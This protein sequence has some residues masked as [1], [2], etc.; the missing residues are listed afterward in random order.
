MNGNTTAA[1]VRSA[2]TDTVT[3]ELRR[4]DL[5]ALLKNVG[6]KVTRSRPL[7]AHNALEALHA[8]YDSP[9]GEA[10]APS[11]STDAERDC[12]MPHLRLSCGHCPHQL[13][14]DCG[15]CCSCP[16]GKS[17]AQDETATCKALEALAELLRRGQT[18]RAGRLVASSCPSQYDI[19]AVLGWKP[20]GD[21][22]WAPD[23]SEQPVADEDMGGTRAH[24][25]RA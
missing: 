12:C 23:K 16:R 6:G 18:W 1:T 2:S 22:A 8:A 17:P 13:C 21:L 10:V 24:A 20:P 3:V 14:Q 7:G 15:N 5:G 4:E 25:G 11:S 9:A 19:C